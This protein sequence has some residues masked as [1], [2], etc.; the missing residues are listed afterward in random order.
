M[1]GDR[2]MFTMNAREYS[3]RRMLT[4]TAQQGYAVEQSRCR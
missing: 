1:T 3:A 4:G 2:R